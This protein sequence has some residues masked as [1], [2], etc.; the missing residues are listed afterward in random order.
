M[1]PKKGGFFIMYKELTKKEIKKFIS[2]YLN[3]CDDY[4]K[5]INHISVIEYNSVKEYL[6]NH[7]YILK[8][9]K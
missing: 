3:P 1:P 4:T 5:K 9:Y 8:I 6:I 2:K 7:K